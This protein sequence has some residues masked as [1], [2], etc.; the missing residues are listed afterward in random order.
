LPIS[1]TTK[2]LY[3]TYFSQYCIRKKYL[4]ESADPFLKFLDLIKTVYNPTLLLLQLT[5]NSTQ[6]PAPVSPKRPQI[7]LQTVDMNQNDSLDDFVL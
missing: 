4:N 6:N 5:V 2:A 3:D 7:A 1:G